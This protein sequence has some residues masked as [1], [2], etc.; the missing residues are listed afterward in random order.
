M[1]V[2]LGN[3]LVRLLEDTFW[4]QHQLGRSAWVCDSGEQGAWAEGR[5]GRAGE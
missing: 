4:D 1:L 2:L 5:E 3:S